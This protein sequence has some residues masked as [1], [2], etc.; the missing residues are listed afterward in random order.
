MTTRVETLLGLTRRLSALVADEIAL[1]EAR[2]TGGLAAR[3]EERDRLTA[4]YAREMNAARAEPGFRASPQAKLSE[5]KDETARFTAA[6]DRHRRLVERMRR[7]TE[8]I[9]KAVADEAARARLPRPG[10]GPGAAAAA[11]SRLAAPVVL[12]ARV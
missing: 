3:A 12:N 11:P 6:L 1:I 4:L 2:D 8:G 10:Y 5:L 7:V 9:V